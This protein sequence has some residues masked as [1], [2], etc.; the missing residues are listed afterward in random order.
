[1]IECR[2]V[3][4]NRTLVGTDHRGAKEVLKRACWSRARA[5]SIVALP[6]VASLATFD[7]FY[8][9]FYLILPQAEVWPVFASE[10]L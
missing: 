10:N 1:M 4:L 6:K 8:F 2:L 3:H 7:S 9:S 5:S